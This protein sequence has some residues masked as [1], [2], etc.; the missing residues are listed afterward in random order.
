MTGDPGCVL[1]PMAAYPLITHGCGDIEVPFLATAGP[2]R[3]SRIVDPDTN[4]TAFAVELVVEDGRSAA[5]TGK[6][7]SWSSVSTLMV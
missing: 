2:L 7:S 5:A 1:V 4:A 3:P 6:T